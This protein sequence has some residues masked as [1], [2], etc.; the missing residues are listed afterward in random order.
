MVTSGRVIVGAKPRSNAVRN[1][2][3]QVERSST[4]I[5]GRGFAWRETG[6]TGQGAAWF[7]GQG[8]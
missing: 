8:V 6:K 1:Q 7:E 2:F 4:G 3:A 5:H